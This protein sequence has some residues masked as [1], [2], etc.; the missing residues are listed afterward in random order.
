M[1]TLFSAPVPLTILSTL[2]FQPTHT[3][4]TS[5]HPIHALPP[6]DL[7]PPLNASDFSNGNC[8]SSTK[9]PSWSSPDWVIEDC[10]TAVQHVYLEEVLSHPNIAYEFL[11]KG[12]SPKRPPPDSQRTPRKYVVRKWDISLH[13][14]W[15]V[16]G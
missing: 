8:A 11:G 2:L 5:T 16:N 10:Y 14:V 1:R 13:C 15:I 9:Y 3:L 4:P 6:L 7:T 12:A